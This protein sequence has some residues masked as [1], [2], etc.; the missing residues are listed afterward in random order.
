MKRY[1]AKRVLIVKIVPKNDFQNL[2]SA[3]IYNFSKNILF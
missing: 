1:Y 2:F 3:R